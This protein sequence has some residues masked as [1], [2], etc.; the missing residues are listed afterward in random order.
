MLGDKRTVYYS[1]TV[2]RDAA[3][4]GYVASSA[5]KM[6]FPADYEEWPAAAGETPQKAVA[7]LA[8]AI[9]KL[10]GRKEVFPIEI[11]HR[12]DRWACTRCSGQAV[13]V[14]R[15][16]DEAKKHIA[17]KKAEQQRGG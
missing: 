16:R 17:E 14:L 10:T 11:R 9:K 7:S 2:Y 8:E 13:H 6:R 1:V 4:D 15:D 12:P 5:F 3:G